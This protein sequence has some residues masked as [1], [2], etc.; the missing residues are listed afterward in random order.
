MYVNLLNE[1]NFTK[2]NNIIIKTCDK[3]YNELFIKKNTNTSSSYENLCNEN[4]KLDNIIGYSLLIS[5]LEKENIINKYIDKVLDP[6]V[7]DLLT[8]DNEKDI[9]KMLVSF[10]SI[11]Q[12]H[13]TFIP[14]RY[15]KILKQLKSNTKSS[16]IRFKI[17]DILG[18]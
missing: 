18:E 16:K 13:Y 17:M 5:H 7:N 2:K 9:Y 8:I 3:Y 11:S 15:Q 1:L 10:Y 6:F 14:E 4:K 12:I